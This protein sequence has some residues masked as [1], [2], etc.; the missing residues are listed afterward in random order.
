MNIL[1]R[2]FPLESILIAFIIVLGSSLF[3][4][5]LSILYN[6]HVSAQEGT[7]CDPEIPIGEAFEKTAEA[8]DNITN[9]LQYVQYMASSEIKAA[10]RAIELSLECD[11]NKCSPVCQQSPYNCGTVD[12][13]QTCYNCDAQTCSSPYGNTPCPN[14]QIQVEFNRVD[15]FFNQI[16][17]SSGRIDGFYGVKDDVQ[18]KL[19]L[20][21]QGFDDCSLSPADWEKVGKGGK[22]EK[23]P[24]SCATVL[25]EDYPR[26][27]EECKSI[28][29]FFCCK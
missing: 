24:L 2:K 23:L 14:T 21:R 16:R 1:R 4:L 3:F 8:A 27:E 7:F 6:N 17:G 18:E 10:E 19:E 13:P 22:A 20:A 5:F 11:I 25:G 15:T 29:N 28:F 12:A 26:K 9:E